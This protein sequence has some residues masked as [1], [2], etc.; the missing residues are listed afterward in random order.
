M[1]WYNIVIMSDN[2]GL[3]AFAFCELRVRKASS[4]VVGW[5]SQGSDRLV[6]FVAYVSSSANEDVSEK[7]RG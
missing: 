5:T 3:F 6:T 4:R 2:E 7:N 1:C